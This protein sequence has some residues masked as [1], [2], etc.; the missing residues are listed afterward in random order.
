MGSAVGVAIG[1]S[2]FN[3]YVSSRLQ[4]LG[5][6]DPLRGLATGDL[7]IL[8]TTMQAEARDILSE[9]YNRQMLVALAFAA[10]QAPAALL[11]WRREQIMTA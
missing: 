2:V 7:S 4:A 11:I 1:T 9:G 6:A 10:A 8:S 5:L 3:G